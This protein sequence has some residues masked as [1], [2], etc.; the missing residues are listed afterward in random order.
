MRAAWTQTQAEPHPQLC[1]QV[2]KHL[3]GCP[4]QAGQGP[5]LCPEG[6]ALHQAPAITGEDADLSPSPQSRGRKQPETQ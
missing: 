3:P 1:A 5:P 6:A 2:W 4:A